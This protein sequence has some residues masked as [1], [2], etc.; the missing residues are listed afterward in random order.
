ML[1]VGGDWEHFFVNESP[2]CVDDQLALGRGF[3]GG[4][5]QVV[6][7]SMRRS[8]QALN[9]V[10][11]ATAPD[12]PFFAGKHPRAHFDEAWKHVENAAGSPLCFVAGLKAALVER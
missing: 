5:A 3:T 12:H 1:H 9:H 8:V 4:L 11:E 6:E 2:Y 7:G 10:H